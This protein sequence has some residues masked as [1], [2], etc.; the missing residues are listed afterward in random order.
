[1]PAPLDETQIGL[2]PEE[3]IPQ[4]F[5]RPASV[6]CAGLASWSSVT[7]DVAS[8]TVA[9]Q[10]NASAASAVPTASAA[11]CDETHCMSDSKQAAEDGVVEI[12]GG[13]VR[14]RLG[15][16]YPRTSARWI[17]GSWTPPVRFCSRVVRFASVA[18]SWPP[19]RDIYTFRPRRP[20]P[21]S[22]VKGNC[23][24]ARAGPPAGP[25]ASRGS[26][27]CLRSVMDIGGVRPL[28]AITARPSVAPRRA[29]TPRSR[30]PPAPRRRG[31]RGR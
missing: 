16:S 18:H 19:R 31:T 12:A 30:P 28:L 7:S 21:R 25:M 26:G 15:G 29:S 23:A 8:K 20:I 6:V 5:F 4:A 1:M 10:G 22:R 11:R 27:K 24:M 17:R 14:R 13:A 9:A 2:A 3:D